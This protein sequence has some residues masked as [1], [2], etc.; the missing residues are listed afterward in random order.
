MKILHINSYYAEGKFYKNLYEEQV[1][2]GASIDVFVPT[3]SAATW[4]LGPYTKV[5]INHGKYDKY[6]FHL[7]HHKI[8][9]DVIKQYAIDHFSL[10][11]AHSLFSNG[12]IAMK[13][14]RE[15]GIP[16]I[17]AVRN[18]DVNAFF[19]YMVHLRSLGVKILEEADGVVF[20]SEAYK[21]DVI[22]RYIPQTLQASIAQK[23]YVIP[24]GID[25]YWFENRTIEKALP[26]SD[27][28]KLLYV[29]AINKNKN[30]TTV[31][32]AIH[33]LQEKGFKIQ[34]TIVGK[35]LDKGIYNVVVANHCV[36][37]CSEKTREE[38][39]TSYRMHDLFIMPSIYET[40][41]LVYAEAMSQAL[42][43]IYS[44]GQG[45]DRQFEEGEVGYSV[46]C[47]SAQE[48][49][50]KIEAIIEQYSVISSNASQ[51]SQ[52][53]SWPGIAD[54]YTALYEGVANHH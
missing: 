43:V 9:K 25:A 3:H 7:K 10:I 17:T 52:K 20:L 21:D 37:Y 15:F 39:L 22:K 49:A 27:A 28:L 6:I 44:R 45:F 38:L 13:L 50:D 32:K 42:P 14:K 36:T 23:S 18:A 46:N 1:K 35:V 47:Y 4:D 41:G 53:F 54:L 11:H 5:S 2:N 31:L 16:Y 8:Y 33:I 30:I 12:Y 40:F 34:F 26:N 29:G 51:N 48:I 24:N 19:K